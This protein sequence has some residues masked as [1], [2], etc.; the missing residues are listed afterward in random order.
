MTSRWSSALIPFCSFKTD[1]N[2]SGNSLVL[3]GMTLPFCSS[4]LPAM[5]E[6]QLCYK[7][8]VNKTSGQGKESELMLLLDYN[9]DRSL[10]TTTTTKKEDMKSLAA[11]KLNLG[12]AVT[13]L[14]GIAA[15]VHIHTLSPYVGFGGGRYKMTAV[16]RMTATS[17]FLEMA[18][19][20]RKCELELYDNCKAKRLLDNCGCVPWEVPHKQV[21]FLPINDLSRGMFFSATPKF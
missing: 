19:E 2:F 5:L 12:T 10:Q 18:F 13:S 1:L 4:F 6:G 21:L 14:H 20:D 16:K 11:T 3:A 17:D 9:E 8:K 15:K 7:L